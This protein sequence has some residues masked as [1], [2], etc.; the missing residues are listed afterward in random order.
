M[1]FKAQ[2]SLISYLDFNAHLNYSKTTFWLNTTKAA[3][4]ILN[5][6]LLYSSVVRAEIKVAYAP[7]YTV[8]KI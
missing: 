8:S 3:A 7:N 2:L 6:G 5:Q 1:Y 4:T